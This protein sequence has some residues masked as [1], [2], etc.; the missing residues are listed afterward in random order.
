MIKLTIK[1][2]LMLAAVSLGTAAHAVQNI[3]T[4]SGI[5]SGSFAIDKLTP[6]SD[7]T[8]TSTTFAD[9]GLTTGGLF[10]GAVITFDSDPQNPTL[11]IDGA[12]ADPILFYGPSIFLNTPAR[13]RFRE[14]SYTLT[15]SLGT[16][17]LT[18]REIDG[19]PPPLPEPPIDGGGG[20]GATVPE[21]A[22][23]ALMIGGFGMA[24]LSLRRRRALAA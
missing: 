6:P 23:W 17:I 21:P 5:Y 11:Q 7:F 15:S 3:F 4:L 24:G 9:V 8:S 14:T 2:A 13:P 19:T 18:V 16:T 12:T 10:E 22:T 1:T 20:S